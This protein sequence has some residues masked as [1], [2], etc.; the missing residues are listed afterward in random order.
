VITGAA[1]VLSRHP[2]LYPDGGDLLGDRTRHVRAA[3]G[4]AWQRL[5]PPRLVLAQ[6]DTSYLAI[7]D[8]SGRVERA[9]SLP[10]AEEGRKIFES[11]LGNKR[12]KLDLESCASLPDRCAGAGGVLVVGSGSLPA[13]ERMVLV[14]EQGVELITLGALY[15]SLRALPDFA[16]SELNIEGAAVHGDVLVLANRGN[17]AACDDRSPTDALI[18]IEL[19][20][21]MAHLR[22]GPLPPLGVPRPLMLGELNGVRLTLTDLCA[23]PGG[24]LFFLAAAE[25]SPNAVDDG[26]VVG[27]ALGRID[28]GGVRLVQLRDEQD[29][30]L[31]SKVEGLVWADPDGAGDEVL[32]VVDRDDPDLPSEC[33]RVRVPATL[34]AHA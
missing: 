8:A 31:A 5:V 28:D 16:G 33:L 3:S 12:H 14:T 2:L 6:D 29:A 7:L 27:T 22:G 11:R 25:A 15:A 9:L 17:G 13:R 24:T 21:L 1:R 32:V 34:L 23:T 4:L 10:H 18:T 19:D 26:E 30:P 20:A